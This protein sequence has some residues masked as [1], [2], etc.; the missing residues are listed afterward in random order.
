MSYEFKKKNLKPVRILV[1]L[2]SILFLQQSYGQDTIVYKGFIIIN[3]DSG[4]YPYTLKYVN[5]NNDISGV[6]V[7]NENLIDNTTNIIKGFYNKKTKSML[8]EEQAIINTNSSESLDRFC[9]LKLELIKKK[10]ALKGDFTGYFND[11]TICAEGEVFLVK[12][13]VLNR[14]LKKLN[15]KILKLDTDT[16]KAEISKANLE[17][18]FSDK[19]PVNPLKMTHQDAYAIHIEDSFV[20]SLWDEKKEDGDM[21]SVLVN[22]SIILDNFVIKNIKHKIKFEK[23]KTPTSIKIIAKNTGDQPPNSINMQLV[24]LKRNVTLKGKLNKSEHLY[25]EVN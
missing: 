13:K 18:K 24:S 15:N 7:T 20:L 17:N 4:V 14:K 22:D 9:F 16:L 25:I 2:L 19:K 21:I 23:I 11:S 1:F 3:N 12:E 8:L 10:N 5:E 6:S